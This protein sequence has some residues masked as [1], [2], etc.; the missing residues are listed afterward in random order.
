[1]LM[2]SCCGKGIQNVRNVFIGNHFKSL[3]ES[4]QIPCEISIHSF[5]QVL[6][7]FPLRALLAVA[8]QHRHASLTSDGD[9]PISPTLVGYFLRRN[10][11]QLVSQRP[12]VYYLQDLTL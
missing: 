11:I 10:T 12:S 2:E 1:M 5:S 3:F 9:G 6:S 8:R 4:F 7:P